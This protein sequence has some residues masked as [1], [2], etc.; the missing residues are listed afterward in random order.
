MKRRLRQEGVKARLEGREKH[1]YSLYRK[2][3][4]KHLSFKEVL[5]VYGFRII[6]ER[7]DDCYRVLGLVHS[8]YKP[9]PERFKDYIAIPKANGYQSLHTTLFGPF[10]SPIEVQIRTEEMDQVAESGVAAHWMY[11]IGQPGTNT[12]Q[13][14]VR[15]WVRES[16]GR[17][18][19]RPATRSSSSRGSRWTSFRRRPTCS[20]RLERFGRCHGE[21]R[22]STLH[23]RCTPTSETSASRP[24][25]T[26]AS[27]RSRTHLSS[28]QTVEIVTME[29][30]RPNAAWL[31]FVV[32]GKA[33]TAIRN[34]LK[35]LRTEDAV[36]LG[37]KLLDQALARRVDRSRRRTGR[38]GR[39][40]ARAVEAPFHRGPLRRNRNRQAPCAPHRQTAREGRRRALGRRRHRPRRASVALHPRLGRNDGGFRQVLSS[41]PRRFGHRIR[42][43]GPRDRR[44]HRWLPKSHGVRGPAQS[45]GWRSPGNGSWRANFR[46]RSAST[47]PTA[48]ACSRRSRRPSPTWAP[49]SRNVNIEKPG[50]ASTRP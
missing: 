49:T 23:T 44:P 27:R 11:K 29:W 22:P 19:P 3:R 25:S 30:G 46:S 18:R 4:T 20:L 45:A 47:W 34:Y 6:V 50:R 9:V 31:D 5:D 33:R 41:H 39:S 37:E 1:L 24:R 14:R 13:L 36:E 35:N 15:E 2:M 17:C 28:G 12:A 26:D 8:L 21:R 40:T 32:S 48:R 16:A 7:P 10:G 43:R 42:E 38:H